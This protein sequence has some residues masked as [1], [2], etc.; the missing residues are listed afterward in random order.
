[1]Y[2]AEIISE[3]KKSDAVT[4]ASNYDKIRLFDRACALTSLVNVKMQSADEAMRFE[5]MQFFSY[6]TEGL[7][8]KK[9][10]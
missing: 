2:S 7:P 1:L 5:S 4:L 10:F 9:R 8:W 6:G 3:S